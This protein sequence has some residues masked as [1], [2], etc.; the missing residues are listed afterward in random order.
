[1]TQTGEQ[2]DRPAFRADRGEPRGER[3]A[4]RSRVRDEVEE[5]GEAGEPDRA[6]QG[7]CA[8]PL[9]EVAEAREQRE[10]GRRRDEPAE[11]RAAQHGR[12]QVRPAR[13]HDLG[14]RRLHELAE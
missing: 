13:D 9:R 11:H 2:G 3:P 7:P 12:D 8:Q 10:P 6:Q 14:A 5:L 4:R 1:M